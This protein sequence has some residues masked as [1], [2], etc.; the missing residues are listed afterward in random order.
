MWPLGLPYLGSIVFYS[1][2]KF[3]SISLKWGCE[4]P[5]RWYKISVDIFNP[6]LIEIFPIGTNFHSL[7]FGP[8]DSNKRSSELKFSP[9]N[10]WSKGPLV[11]HGKI[12]QVLKLSCSSFSCPVPRTKIQSFIAVKVSDSESFLNRLPVWTMVV[13]EWIANKGHIWT[14][15]PPPLS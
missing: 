2:W 10:P 11:L 7:L 4:F 3:P 9:Q 12:L 15:H 1:R 6:F 13:T 5:W 8:K 14:K